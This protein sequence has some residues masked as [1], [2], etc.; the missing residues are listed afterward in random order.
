M[1]EF[2]DETATDLS[3]AAT[4]DECDDDNAIESASPAPQGKMI[5]FEDPVTVVYCPHCTLTPELCEYG[6][7]YEDRCQPWILEHCPEILGDSKLAEMVGDASLE[8]GGE[9]SYYK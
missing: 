2:I 4:A 1:S 3:A 8:E 7:F 9:V 6:P 5:D